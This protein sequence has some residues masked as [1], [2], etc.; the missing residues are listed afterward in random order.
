M[1]EA[2]SAIRLAAAGFSTP[3]L[4]DSLDAL[5]LVHQIM[6][7]HVRPLD[8]RLVLCGRARTG[9]YVELPRAAGNDDRYARA[10]AFVDSLRTGDVPVLACGGSPHIQPWGGLFSQAARAR[11]ATGCITDGLIRDVRQIR[12]LGFPVYS[13][14]HS[15]MQTR[16]RSRLETV[17]EPVHCGG[18]WVSP[19]DLIF[20]DVDGVVVI[21]RDVEADVLTRAAARAG[22]GREAVRALRE[23][24]SIAELY[25]RYGQL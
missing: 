13:T 2:Q 22:H 19:G 11:G 14:G 25:E 3:V 12:E 6:A 7:S 15:A 1:H 10:L 17:D 23:G 21:P 18:V 9:S 24:L 8:E 4:S 16:G 20:G 5:G